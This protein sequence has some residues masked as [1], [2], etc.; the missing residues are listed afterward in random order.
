MGYKKLTGIEWSDKERRLIDELDDNSPFLDVNLSLAPFVVKMLKSPLLPEHMPVLKLSLSGIANMMNKSQ[1]AS[2]LPSLGSTNNHKEK[3][4]E[5]ATCFC[6][7]DLE[8][9]TLDVLRDLRN[10]L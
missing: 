5:I 4:D 8:S 1:Y 3:L 6:S 9:A 7:R 10:Q 2:V